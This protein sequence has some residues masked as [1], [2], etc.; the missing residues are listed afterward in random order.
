MIKNTVCLNM[1]VKNESAVIQRC[2]DSLKELIDYWVI[3][4]TGSTDGT[5]DIIQEALKDIPG[6]LHER[7]WVNFMHNRNEAY[8]L[9]KGH[10]DYFLFID[11]D[12]WL[13]F[14]QA[15][16]WP[17]LKDDYYLAAYLHGSRIDQRILL[18]NSRF[19]WKWN[20]IIHEAIECPD[21][22]K[23]AILDD[24][25]IHAT[26][27]GNRSKDLREK[28][29]SDARI[30]EQALQD[31]PVNKRYVF[32]LAGSYGAAGE[33]ELALKYYK[34]RIA[35]G[36]TSLEVFFS[37]YQKAVLERHL[38]F[39][40]EEFIKSY[41]QA[42]LFRPTRAEPFFCLADYYMNNQCYILGYL[43]SKY[44][45]LIAD[46]KDCFC[47]QFA[48]NDYGL[49]YQLAE[50]AVRIGK[51]QEAYEALKQLLLVETLP[52]DIREAS[53]KNLALPVFDEFRG[54]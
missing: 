46:R 36:D 26:Q 9:A 8:A 7:P 27:E 15:F 44:G 17:D 39:A 25:Y 53:E 47:N 48:I 1:I 6:E 22:L 41:I 52:Q 50:C 28:F 19:D 30:L 34:H 24:P 49:L 29:L 43:F 37:I 14:K 16:E 21:A 2:L 23:E 3:V 11:A 10:G 4:D 38:G 18:V 33:Y 42:Y 12:E 54:F 45:L 32:H 20:G 40:P 5:Q 51:Y 35:L 31:D 13:V